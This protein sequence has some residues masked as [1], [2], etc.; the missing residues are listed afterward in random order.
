MVPE[1]LS[2]RRLLGFDLFARG[3]VGAD[4]QI[5]DDRLLASRSA[6]TDTTAGKRVPSLR[7]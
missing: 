5:A 4:E 3:V 7:M 2:Q 1:P 6:V